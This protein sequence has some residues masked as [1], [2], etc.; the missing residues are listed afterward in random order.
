MALDNLE[1]IT[2][3]FYSLM[4]IITIA[5]NGTVILS[6]V[7]IKK[8]RN[9]S[10]YFIVSLSCA[11]FCIGLLTL[12][13]R[14]MEILRLDFTSS[15]EFCRVA[16]VFTLFN[17][18][19][20]VSN[21]V[22]ITVDRYIAIIHPYLYVRLK[23]F[24]GRYVSSMLVLAWLPVILLTCLPLYGWGSN[25]VSGR[26][27]GELGICTFSE[28]MTPAFLLTILVTV[29]ATS[30]FVIIPLYCRIFIIAKSQITK[31]QPVDDHSITVCSAPTYRCTLAS[32]ESGNIDDNSSSSNL[33]TTQTKPTYN[34]CKRQQIREQNKQKRR[35]FLISWKTTTTMFLIVVIFLISWMAFVIPTTM[36]IICKSCAN[37]TAV[38]A[39]TVIIYG[40][41]AINPFIYFIRFRSFQTE[42]KRIWRRVDRCCCRKI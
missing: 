20:S 40:G 9:T 13:L 1:I 41:S 10:N 5:A 21:L 37:A 4:S 35:T 12:P 36:F 22:V 8:L 42:I 26:R 16:H 38:L 2:L 18:T 19:A 3:T 6:M 27:K 31:V 33:D 30:L 25:G 7:L 29:L 39:C 34:T 32:F 14:S 24:K 23:D 17:F 15:T 28:T 11:D